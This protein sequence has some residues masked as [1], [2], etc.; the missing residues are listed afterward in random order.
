MIIACIN[1]YRLGLGGSKF[2]AKNPYCTSFS[3]IAATSTVAGVV[4]FLAAPRAP[5]AMR[6]SEPKT[7]VNCEF[8]FSMPIRL[9]ALS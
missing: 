7:F 8:I 3:T 4:I 6:A 5:R 2:I 9:G 1:I